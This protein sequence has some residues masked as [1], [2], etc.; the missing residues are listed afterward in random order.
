MSLEKEIK[1]MVKDVTQWR[2]DLHENPETAFEEFRTADIVAEKLKEWGIETHQNIGRTGVVGVLKGRK[3]TSGKTIGL[4]ADMDALNIDENNKFSHVS[5]TCGKMHACGHDGH[6]AMLLGAAKYLAQNP[7]FDGTVNFIFQPAEE[8]G[9]G[10]DVMIKDKLFEK[11][12][13]DEVYALHNWPDM[14]VG[15]IG[16][17]GGPVTASSDRFKITIKGKGGHAAFPHKH[18]DSIAIGSTISLALHAVVSSN[19]NPLDGA[20]VSVTKFHGGVSTNAMPEVVELEG[21]VRCFNPETR[22][23]LEEQIQKVAQGIALGY[24]AVAEVEYTRNYPSVV[25]TED[26]VEF[27]KKVAAKTVGEKNVLNFRP[28]MGSEDFAFMLQKKPGVYIA[29]GQADAD[30]NEG[31]HSPRYDFNDAVIPHGIKYWVTLAKEALPLNAKAPAQSP[32]KQKKPA[33]SA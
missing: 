31:L 20:L 28:T 27:I 13:C 18:I 10:A 26:K 19:T 9:G 5:K 25:N 4:R 23:A 12:P 30:H 33:A 21:T 3:N 24:G 16:V 8:G 15:E 14:K 17:A 7:D 6:T 22:L 1:E 11:F 2:R 32:K 29:L